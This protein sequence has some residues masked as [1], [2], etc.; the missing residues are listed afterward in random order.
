MARKE[1]V[2]AR[3]KLFDRDDLPPAPRQRRSVARRKRLEAAALRVFA[4]RGYDA[5]TVEEIAALAET[6]V[7]G[8]YLHFRSKRQLLVSLMDDLLEQLAGLSLEPASATSPR[9][10]LRDLLS[11]GFQADLRY[12]GAYRAWQA[13]VLS[14]VELARDEQRIRRWTVARVSHVFRELLQQPGA[15]SDEVVDVD[16]LARVMDALFWN[17][18]AQAARSTPSDLA[19]SIDSVTHLL[20]HALFRDS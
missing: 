17:L 18:L 4:E 7:G 2:V 8:F 19:R 16:G 20:H 13:A 9:D 12:L 6:A 3:P 11:R 10:A 15:R 14:D 5:A 1:R